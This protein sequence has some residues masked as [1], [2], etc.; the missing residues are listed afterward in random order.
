[1]SFWYSRRIRYNTIKN[2]SKQQNNMNKKNQT[3]KSYQNHK[4]RFVSLKTKTKDENPRSFCAKILNETDCYLTFFDV[5]S[6]QMIKVSKK[7]II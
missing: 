1:M 5:N 4:G 2:K 3:S 7:S 6:K